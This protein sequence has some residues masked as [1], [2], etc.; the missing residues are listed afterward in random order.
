MPIYHNMPLFSQLSTS[1]NWT[2]LFTLQQYAYTLGHDN[3]GFKGTG[4]REQ[5]T[6]KRENHKL[7]KNCRNCEITASDDSINTP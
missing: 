2:F 1:K 3:Y 5:G 7:A 4:N 6:E